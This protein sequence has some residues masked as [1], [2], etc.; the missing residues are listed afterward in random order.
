MTLSTLWLLPLT[1]TKSLKIF[2]H[3]FSCC[4][5]FLPTNLHL[6]LRSKAFLLFHF[7]FCARSSPNFFF[8]FNKSA[9]SFHYICIYN[10]PLFHLYLSI[11]LIIYN[12]FL[13]FRF[14]NELILLQYFILFNFKA[15][16][17]KLFLLFSFMNPRFFP[18]YFKSHIF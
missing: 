8:F 7:V 13:Q 4:T 3:H 9:T 6:L 10:N 2:E 18:I 14:G 16:L 15:K 11:Y 1:P 5:S 17:E 12:N